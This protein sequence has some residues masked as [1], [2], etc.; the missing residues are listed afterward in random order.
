MYGRGPTGAALESLRCS[1]L[2]CLRWSSW[3]WAG[4]TGEASGE[5]EDPLDDCVAA[6]GDWSRSAGTT[7]FRR[8][9]IVF[10]IVVGR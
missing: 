8:F 6:V 7:R 10:F 4:T 2:R 9:M 1:L 5:A 3:K